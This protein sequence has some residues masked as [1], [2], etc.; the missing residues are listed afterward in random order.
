MVTLDPQTQDAT[1]DSHSLHRDQLWMA[2]NKLDSNPGTNFVLGSYHAPRSRSTARF[3]QKS[4]HC[5]KTYS[6]VRYFVKVLECL[7]GWLY[8]QWQLN[9]FQ[10]VTIQ[11]VL[12]EL[13]H[14]DLLILRSSR[15]I[16]RFFQS[17]VTLDLEHANEGIHILEEFACWFVRFH[18]NLVCLD[19]FVF[20]VVPDRCRHL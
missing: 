20:L 12:I 1:S 17:W 16:S 13:Q 9:H 6:K 14:V 18:V 4:S 7:Y 15:S 3:A 10:T 19:C 2:L 5:S 11:A 8:I